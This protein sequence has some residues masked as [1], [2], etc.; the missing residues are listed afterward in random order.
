[1]FGDEI[2]KDL[3]EYYKTLGDSKIYKIIKYSTEGGKCIRGFIVKHIIDTLSPYNIHYWEPIVCVELLHS[4][5]LI[6][7]DLPCMD[8]D[9]TRRGKL[10]TFVAFGERQAIVSSLYLVS[11]SLKILFN[12][13]NKFRIVL[14]DADPNFNLENQINLINKLINEWSVLLGKNL[15]IGQMLDLKEDV[16]KLLNIK[17]PEKNSDKLIMIY[18]TCS[19]FMF[20]FVVGAVFCGKI[21]YAIIDEF[22]Q[23]GLHFG[24]MFQIMDDFKDINEDIHNYNYV[25]ENGKEKAL[26][27]YID[28]RNKLVV[29]LKKHKFNT[30]K[31]KTL[32]TKI[33]TYIPTMSKVNMSPPM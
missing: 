29:L 30:T 5:S 9:T 6:I 14:K 16:E 2:V 26:H 18:K 13:L 7:D 15:I 11:E 33:D 31:F 19:L 20:C 23:M 10:S 3:E 28:S 22:K 25:L 21:D 24:I 17:I 1:M 27:V 12:S 4:S 8:N 32:I